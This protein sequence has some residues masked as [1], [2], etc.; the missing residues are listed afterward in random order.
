M[1]IY[2][3]SRAEDFA[4]QIHLFPSS[5]MDLPRV[6]GIRG[7]NESKYQKCLSLSFI[8]LTQDPLIKFIQRIVSC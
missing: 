5:L 3:Y 4:L 2:M 6:S 1:C 8:P 7:Y